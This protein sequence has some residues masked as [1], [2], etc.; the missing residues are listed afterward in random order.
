MEVGEKYVS[1]S[2]YLTFCTFI[3]KVL[4]I[5]SCFFLIVNQTV[6]KLWSLMLLI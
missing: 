3:K 4:T 5:F 1:D 2:I 6:L